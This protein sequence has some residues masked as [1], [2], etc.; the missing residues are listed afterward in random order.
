MNVF[1]TS[2]ISSLP[3]LVHILPMHETLLSCPTP[4]SPAAS[5]L[6]I[7]CARIRKGGGGH[8]LPTIL[9]SWFCS[10]F[11]TEGWQQ[12]EKLSPIHCP[13]KLSWFLGRAHPDLCLTHPPLGSPNG[14]LCWLL[15]CFAP[16]DVPFLW[17]VC[18]YLTYHCTPVCSAILELR[19]N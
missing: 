16:Y 9:L 5:A 14:S 2:K 6:S 19:R 13:K 15:F 3:W 12:V 17:G 11:D 18:L 1:G 4:G 10:S 8:Y 7:A